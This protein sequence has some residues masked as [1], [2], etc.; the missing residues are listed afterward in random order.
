MYLDT[1][2]ISGNMAELMVNFGYLEKFLLWR[3][4]CWQKSVNQ[5]HVFLLRQVSLCSRH[6][7]GVR[8]DGAYPI[9]DC[10]EDLQILTS[11][12]S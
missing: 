3:R 9:I 5:G 1:K 2:E 10:P 4:K 12:N 8:E 11:R 7:F 6:L